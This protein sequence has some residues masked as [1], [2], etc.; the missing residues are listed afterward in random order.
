LNPDA[1]LAGW[2][3][4]CTRNL[5]L[6]LRRDD[7]RRHS[8]ERQAMETLHPSPETPPDWD[9]LRPILDEAISGLNDA[10]H[11][12]LVLRFFKNHDLRTV[13]LMMGVSADTA[14]KRVDRALEKLRG[15]LAQKGITTTAAA[16]SVVI[17]ANAIQAAPVGLA[18]TISA[19]ATIAPGPRF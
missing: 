12:A 13:G 7:F 11:D 9:R 15:H 3:C 2:L 6:N 14:Q 16:L 4:R 10:D 5:A 17:A 1:S 18:V 8:R 19:A